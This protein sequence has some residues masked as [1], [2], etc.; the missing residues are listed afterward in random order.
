MEKTTKIALITV[1]ACLL[2]G[3]VAAGVGAK[4]TNNYQEPLTVAYKFIG[5]KFEDATYTAD[6]LTHNLKV[7]GLDEDDAKS[8]YKIYKV[9]SITE[10]TGTADVGEYALKAVVTIDDVS[11]DYLATLT[12]KAAA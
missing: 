7:T 3:G 5:V 1:A 10:F 12:I 6:T 4:L 11:R 9:N 2:A 8:S